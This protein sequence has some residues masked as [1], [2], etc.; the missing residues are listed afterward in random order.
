MSVC[1]NCLR[2][3]NTEDGVTRHL[4]QPLT[5]CHRWHDELVTAAEVLQEDDSAS[6][7]SPTSSPGHNSEP[8]S[9][10]L[11]AQD[12]LQQY[13]VDSTDLEDHPWTD[14]GDDLMDVDRTSSPPNHPQELTQI[15]KFE[16]AGKIMGV[17]LSFM[18]R[19]HLDTFT[20]NRKTNIYYP[21]ASR[22]DWSMASYLLRSGLSMKKIDEYLSLSMVRIGSLWCNDCMLTILRWFCKGC[23]TSLIISHRKSSTW[24]G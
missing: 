11:K 10:F 16:G 2:K 4:N 21:F 8:A 17:G 7:W 24:P 9:G 15:V 14:A 20:E 22:D 1:P 12:I 23:S 19:F 6:C 5:T 18:D 13:I 3:F